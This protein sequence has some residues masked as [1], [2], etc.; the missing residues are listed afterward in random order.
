MK[1]VYNAPIAEIVSFEIEEK[2][3]EGEPDPSAS[4]TPGHDE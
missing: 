1:D 3:L 2:L 4:L